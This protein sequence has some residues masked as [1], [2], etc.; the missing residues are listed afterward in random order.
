MIKNRLLNHDIAPTPKLKM[1]HFI[2]VQQLMNDVVASDADFVIVGGDF[3]AQPKDDNGM[4]T[5]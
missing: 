1:L 3:N 5:I 4:N 2:Q